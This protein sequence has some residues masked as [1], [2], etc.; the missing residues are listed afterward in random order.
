MSRELKP[1]PTEEELEE[2]LQRSEGDHSAAVGERVIVTQILLMYRQFQRTENPADAAA[3]FSEA[4][5]MGYIP[6]SPLLEWVGMSFSKLLS[7]S[8]ENKNVAEAFGFKGK[9]GKMA[10]FQA[11]NYEMYTRYSM[12]LM[13]ESIGLLDVSPER[14]GEMVS[15]KLESEGVRKKTPSAATLTDYYN[16][17]R[18]KFRHIENDCRE[19]RG[20][21]EGGFGIAERVERFVRQFPIDSLP[22]DI[23]E[24]YSRHLE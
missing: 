9:R 2:L 22:T 11:R 24:K 13:A 1:L 15:R 5:S 7:F 23:R 3:A 12:Y 16:R 17:S 21:L 14:A 6:P 10:P 20:N 8:D 19:M 18:E 4:V